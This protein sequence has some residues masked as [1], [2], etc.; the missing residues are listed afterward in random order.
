MQS[1]QLTNDILPVINRYYIKQIHFIGIGGA[2]MSGIAIIL[3]HQGYNVTGSDI[4]ESDITQYLLNLGVKIFFG[5]CS[6]NVNNADLVVISSA[7]NLNNIEFQAAKRLKIPIMRRAEVLFELMRYKY[8]IAIAGTHGKTTTT[9]MLANIYVEAGLDPTF[10]NGAIIRSE[11]VQSRFGCSCYFIIEADESD[12][13]FLWLYPTVE[14]ITNIDFDHMSAYQNNY[15]FLK[16]AFVEFLNHLPVYGYAVICIDDPAIRSVLS[17]VNRKIITYGF[18]KD[19]DLCILNYHQYREKSKFTVLIKNK[20]KLE[21]ILNIPGYHNVLNATASIGVSIEEGIPD[22]V[23]LRAMLNFQGTN[24]RFEN[25]GFYSLKQINGRVGKVMIVDDYG[26]H[27]T[28]LHATIATVRSGWPDKRLIMVFQ[29]HRFTRTCE[30]YDSFIHVLST[31]DVLLILNVYP[32]GEKPI[33]NINSQ[34]LCDAINK[35]GKIKPVFVSNEYILLKILLGLLDNGD[36]LL[37]Q[38]A[39]TIGNKMRALFLKNQKS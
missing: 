24:R 34:T 37:I 16:K 3:A 33:L 26:H 13:S 28:E 22:L 35:Y 29:P 25:L 4:E 14:I 17:N 11:G 31:V 6:E 8:G 30:L 32:A 23:I 12:K 10:I 1:F 36:L 19:A 2:G 7:I 9:A 5:H 21:I 27:P 15:E 39:G 18:S 38:G 20:K